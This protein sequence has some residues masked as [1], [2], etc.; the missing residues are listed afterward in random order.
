MSPAWQLLVSAAAA[1]HV[2]TA[3]DRIVSNAI[4]T[5]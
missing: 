5:I 2:S 4:I 1:A 3:A